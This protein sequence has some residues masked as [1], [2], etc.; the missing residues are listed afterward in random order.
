MFTANVTFPGPDAG[1]RETP[2]LTGYHPQIRAGD[3]YTSCRIMSVGGKEVFDLDVE[4]LVLLELLFPEE[5]A[6]CI[7]P[8]DAVTFF[9]GSHQVGS[10]IILDVL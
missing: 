4:H 1:G 8:G 9:E 2:P 5:Y 3:V 6:R 10:G 7:A